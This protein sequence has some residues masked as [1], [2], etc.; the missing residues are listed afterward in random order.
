MLLARSAR[1]ASGFIDP[2]LPTAAPRPPVG[3]DWLHE[4]KH[5]GFRLQVIRGGDS[6]RLFTKNGNDWSKRYP[7]IVDAAG[8]L[9]A[10]SFVLDGEVVCCDSD[11]LAV[12]ELLRSRRHDREAFLYAFDL[13]E[14]DGEDLRRVELEARKTRLERLLA[15]APHG[16][17]FSEHL[18]GDG[19]TIFRHAC[20]L[21]VEGIVS[22]RRT[23]RYRSGR[24]DDWRKTKNPQSVAARREAEEEWGKDRA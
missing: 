3:P 17:R 8:A 19:P 9:R 1:R 18:I 12:F 6:V 22:K 11:G 7:A 5:D 15:R 23:S 4:I 24:S 10:G 2:C 16:I 13:L 14:L 21:G 20:A